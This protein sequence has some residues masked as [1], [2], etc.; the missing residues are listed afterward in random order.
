MWKNEAPELSKEWE[1]TSEDCLDR[2]WKYKWPGC[3]FVY[4]YG[5]GFDAT[6]MGLD[7][8]FLGRY[9]MLTGD[10]RVKSALKD[11]AQSAMNTSTYGHPLSLGSPWWKH[12]FSRFNNG[13]DSIP[14]MILAVSEDPHYAR[15]VEL[16]RKRF[17]SRPASASQSEPLNTYYNMLAPDI[18]VKVAPVENRTFFSK[19]ENGSALRFNSL[20]VAMPWRSW[21][22]STCGACYSTPT[23]VESEICSVILTAVTREAGQKPDKARYPAAYSIVEQTHPIP[24]VRAT[25]IGEGFI[26]SATSFRPALGGPAVPGRVDKENLSPW[27]RTDMWFADCN[28]F[29]GSLELSALQDNN[30]SKVALWMHVSDKLKIDGDAV[31]LEGLTITTERQAGGQVANLGKIWGPPGGWY[32]IDLLESV[33]KESGAEGFQ[34]GETFDASVAV[35]VDGSRGLTVGRRSLEDGLYTVEILRG[36][37]TY[38]VLLFNSSAQPKVRSVDNTNKAAYQSKGIT[39]EVKMVSSSKKTAL[40]PGSLTVLM[41]ALR[42]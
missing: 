29:A 11:M 22:E 8:G 39:G 24:D 35:N 41:A 26:A 23:A 37:E 6:Y 17:F 15:V 12:T 20:N 34:K 31:K 3:G 42:Q 32:P 21:S 30:C 19:I 36:K 38:A 7:G 14:E 9:Y 16:G 40:P 4:S 13:D 10:E 25:I 5:S 27:R 18:Q 28:G 2:A 33:L 1:R